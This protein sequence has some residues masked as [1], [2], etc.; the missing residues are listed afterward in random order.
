MLPREKRFPT[1]RRL[2]GW[3]EYQRLKS[4]DYVIVSFGKSGRTWLRVMISRL[5][6]QKYGL[7]EGSLIEF[8]NFHRVNPAIPRI[9]F[10]HDN[11]LRHFTGDGGDK[12][13]FAGKKVV[14]LIRHPADI[15]VSQYFQWK[16]RMRDH[17]IALNEYP[18]RSQDIPLFDFMM[19]P[20][21]LPKVITWLNEWA[22][23]LDELP[24]L[25][26]VRYE[27]LRRD[28]V[29]A[30]TRVSEFLSTAA[31]KEQVADAAEWARFENMKQR[32]AESA[33][34]SGRLKAAD[35]NNPDSFKTRR[36]Q[37]GGYRNDFDDAQLARIDRLVADTL[38]PRYGYGDATPHQEAAT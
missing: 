6:Q 2:R 11:Y 3:L 1:E 5:Y 14:L 34:E 15:A 32:E 33:S 21:G 9:F 35:V 4:A 23:A 19:G 20:S 18:P 8:A 16:H 37:A 36:A 38:D 24:D 12:A 30:L 13:A 29:G 31:T 28:A 7:P 25:L 27:D 17:K 10:T 22:P 26:V